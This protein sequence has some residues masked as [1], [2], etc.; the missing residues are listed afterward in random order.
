LEGIG[1]KRTFITKMVKKQFEQELYFNCNKFKTKVMVKRW[2]KR[3]ERKLMKCKMPIEKF[4][5]GN[6]KRYIVKQRN[7]CLFSKAMCCRSIDEGVK[8]VIGKL[9]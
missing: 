8:A 7:R 4:E 6:T 9:K 1:T 5:R 2:L 3:N